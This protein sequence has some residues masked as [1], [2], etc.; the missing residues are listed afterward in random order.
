MASHFFVAI[1]PPYLPYH[2]ALVYLSGAL[3]IAGAAG[4]L[5]PATRRLAGAGLILLT[6]AVFPA[7]VHM[8]LNPEQFDAFAQW[9]LLARLPLQALIIWWIWFSTQAHATRQC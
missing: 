1:M 9:L 2:L 8:A 3:E 4:V 7:N 5:V 6:I